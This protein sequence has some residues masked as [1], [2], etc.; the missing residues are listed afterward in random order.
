MESWQMVR[1]EVLKRLTQLRLSSTVLD[2]LVAHVMS[3]S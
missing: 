1:V 2:P 3:A